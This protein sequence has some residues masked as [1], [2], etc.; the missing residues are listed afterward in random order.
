MRVGAIFLFV[1]L[2]IEHLEVE[3][4]LNRNP[5]QANALKLRVLT[6]ELLSSN[7]WTIPKCSQQIFSFVNQ[8]KQSRVHSLAKS[9]QIPATKWPFSINSSRLNVR[10]FFKLIIS[11]GTHSIT[12]LQREDFHSINKKKTIRYFKKSNRNNVFHCYC[13]FIWKFYLIMS[14]EVHIK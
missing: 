7:A 14:M 12:N 8:L 9:N 10:H 5:S 11:N 2:N 4:P 1:R 3:K 13:F 6:C